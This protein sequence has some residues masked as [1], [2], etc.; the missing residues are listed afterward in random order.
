MKLAY[1]QLDTVEEDDDEDEEDDSANEKDEAV[2]STDV[3]HNIYL[4][5]H[6]VSLDQIWLNSILSALSTSSLIK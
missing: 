3:G 6:Q 4:L 5:A 2:N 1:H